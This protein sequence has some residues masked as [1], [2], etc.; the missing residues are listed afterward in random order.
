MKK[1]ILVFGDIILDIF[2]YGKFIKMSP[3]APVPT[4]RTRN[5]S[6]FNLGGAANVCSNINSLGFK[7]SLMSFI[8][9]DKNSL[10]IRNLLN[11]RKI[12]N[13][14]VMEKKFDIT[15]KERIFNNFNPVIRLD[16]DT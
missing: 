11:N 13:L 6:F 4:I 15:V 5:N 12:S 10:K 14:C 7:S 2:T 16:N 1:K 8:G 9:N 3:E